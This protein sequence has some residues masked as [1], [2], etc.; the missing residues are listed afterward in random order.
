MSSVSIG[1]LQ[2]R[3][4]TPPY[5]IFQLLPSNLELNSYADSKSFGF[6]ID[7]GNGHFFLLPSYL[8]SLGITWDGVIDYL[9]LSPRNQALIGIVS[10]YVMMH[11]TFLYFASYLYNRRYDGCSIGSRLVVAFANGIWIAFPA[12]SIYAC[13]HVVQDDSWDIFRTN[14][15]SINL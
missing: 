3:T 7:V 8:L 1:W 4:R 14:N 9:G 11:G 12:L 6:W 13:W 5:L 10:N 2:R 15:Y